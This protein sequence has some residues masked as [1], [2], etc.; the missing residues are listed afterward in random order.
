ME[1][2]SQSVPSFKWIKSACE[3]R[4]LKVKK[5]KGEKINT[6]HLILIEK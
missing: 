2:Q 4:N 5:L 1:T 6:Q 3:K